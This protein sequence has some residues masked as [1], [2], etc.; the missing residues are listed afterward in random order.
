MD[1][2]AGLFNQTSAELAREI[3]DGVNQQLPEEKKQAESDLIQ[4][5]KE[6]QEV[7]SD[8]ADG[9]GQMVGSIPAR[10]YMR[11][12]QL[13]PGCWNDRSFVN[14]FLKDNPQCCAVGY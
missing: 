7:G 12:A 1:S 2:I 6:L 3:T 14:E 5:A 4:T 9:R 11:W 8:R 13:L 10:V